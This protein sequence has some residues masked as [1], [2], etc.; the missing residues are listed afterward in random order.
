MGFIPL[1]PVIRC[2]SVFRCFLVIL[3]T[4]FEKLNQSEALKKRQDGDGKEIERKYL[5]KFMLCPRLTLVLSLSNILTF[6]LSV[7]YT[8]LPF[9]LLD[10]LIFIASMIESII[11]Y[12]FFSSKPLRRLSD[13]FCSTPTKIGP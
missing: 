6:Y 13:Y 2:F 5:L 4:P 10:I 8:V 11:F 9:F 7:I 1:L 3:W 12:F